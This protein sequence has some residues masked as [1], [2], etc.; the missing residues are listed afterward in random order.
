MGAVRFSVHDMLSLPDLNEKDQKYFEHGGRHSVRPGPAA[1]IWLAERGYWI[2][3]RKENIDDKSK[4]NTI[5][6]ALVLL[7]VSWMVCQCI[8]RRIC[9]LPLSLLEIHTVVHVAC[10]VF[11]YACWFAVFLYSY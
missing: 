2:R 8:A 10:A 1:I 6:K 3:I 7:Q 5:Q 4:A 11:L 9:N